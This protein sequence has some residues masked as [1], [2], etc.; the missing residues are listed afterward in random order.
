MAHLV[1]DTFQFFKA[2]MNKMSSLTMQENK[3]QVVHILN[4]QF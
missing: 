1:V 2:N 3:S 4:G